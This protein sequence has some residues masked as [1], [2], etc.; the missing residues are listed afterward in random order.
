[1][2]INRFLTSLLAV[3]LVGSCIAVAGAYETPESIVAAGKV[4]IS[5]ISYDPGVFFSGDTGTATFVVTNGNT[6]QGVVVN[7]ATFSDAE[8]KFRLTSD[9]FQNSAQLGPGKSQAFTFTVRADGSEGFYYPVFSLSFRDANSLF[10]RQMVQIDDTPLILTVIDKPDAYT[11]GKKKTVSMQVANPRKNQVKNVVLELSG[12]GSDFA[13]SRVFVGNIGPGE[14]IPVNFS[15]TPNKAAPIRLTLNYDNGDNPHTV[16]MDLPVVFGPDKKA[17]NPVMSNVQVKNDAGT[18]HITGDVNNAG[19]E[20]A[21]TVMVTSLSPAVPQDPY[22]VYVVGA[23]KTDDFGSFEVT[24]TAENTDSIPI[25]L[26]YKDIDGN[27]YDT[28]QDVKISSSGVTAQK[29]TSSGLPVV[30]IAAGIA[31]LVV[32]IGG[33]VYYLRRKKQ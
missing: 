27:V 28:I 32:F 19:L 20:T 7:H 29:S 9:T 23:L 21:N 8:N 1:M 5:N 17:A 26:S 14:K 4:Y 18:W 11:Q 22:K 13:P 2:Q 24:C 30:P 3:L 31:L 10:S 33:W 12:D 15:I 16:S 6:D 25:K